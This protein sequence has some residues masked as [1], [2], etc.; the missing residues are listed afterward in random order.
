MITAIG[1]FI[2]NRDADTSGATGNEEDEATAGCTADSIYSAR[3][4]LSFCSSETASDDIEV[5]DGNSKA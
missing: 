1:R 2:A 3:G 4:L 5:V